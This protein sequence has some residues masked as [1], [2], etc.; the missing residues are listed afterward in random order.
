MA[1][2]RLTILVTLALLA[3]APSTRADVLLIYGNVSGG[4]M[5]GKGTGGDQKGEDFFQNA[6]N[7]A[8][9][10]S[11]T[12]RF[13]FFAAEISHHQYAFFGGQEEN[14]LR[15]W[16][17]FS[18][19]LDFD[20]GLGTEQEKKQ[21]KGKYVNLG[22]FAGF[23][24]GTGQ[25][26]DPPLDNGQVTDKG[27]VLGGRLGIGTHLSKLFDFGLQVPVFY[28][29]YFKNGVASNDVSNH[30]QGVHAEALLYLR[31]NIKLL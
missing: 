26:V 20:V 6:P 13:L 27:F 16:T 19:G 3:G 28:G 14:S 2:P 4:G 12:G 15:T 7:G 1:F 5:A 25:Q 24:L 10:L 23:G 9:G 22:A 31:L 30:Y 18:A 17:Q 11:V 29:Y 21:H 8:Y